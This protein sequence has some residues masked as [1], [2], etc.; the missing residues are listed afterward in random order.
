MTKVRRDF[1]MDDGVRIAA[2]VYG[3]T[4]NPPVILAHGGGQTRHAWGGT[5]RVLARAGWHAI[6]YD[7]RGHGE[8]GWSTAGDY[9]LDRLAEDLRTIARSFETPPVIIGASL[10]GLAAMIG[11]GECEEELLSGVVLVD[12][13]PNMDRNG[14]M[15][16]VRFMGQ[17]VDDG[18]ATLDEAA[19]VIARYTGRPRRHNPEGLEKNLRLGDDGRYRWHWDPAFMSEDRR[20][21]TSTHIDIFVE[22]A[23]RL[24]LPVLLVRGRMSDVVSE[25][26]AQEFLRIVP[27][28]EYVD[29]RD[30]HHMV[31]GDRNDAFTGPVV[32]FL[33]RL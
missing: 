2:D 10:G 22:H 28:A 31:A 16:V 1:L 21:R 9:S 14:A 23:R 26:T 32:S 27:H 33:Q 5:A 8:S 7:H 24:T 25:E 30:A 29:V 18:F 19:D 15:A 20:P 12:I 11:Q 6:A 13:T 4:A 17:N 3:P